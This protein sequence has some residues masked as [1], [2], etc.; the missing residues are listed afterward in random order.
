MPLHPPHRL[1]LAM[2]YLAILGVGLSILL[3]VTHWQLFHAASGG[4]YC[5]VNETFDCRTVALSRYAVV[6]GLPLP[7]WGCAGFLTIGLAAWL[8]SRLAFPLALLGAVLSIALLLEEVLHVGAVCLLCEGVHA[9][10]VILAVLAFFARRQPGT[11]PLQW[12]REAWVLA[13]G[14]LGLLVAA[15]VLPPYWAASQWLQ[16][17]QVPHGED[18]AGHPWIGAVEPRLVIEEWVDYRCPHCAVSSRRMARLV[19]QH[20]EV[21]RLV[22]R[23][24]P[25]LRCHP[26]PRAENLCLHVRAAICAGK[27]GKFWEMDAWLFAQPGVRTRAD[28]EP[29]LASQAIAVDTFDA[30]LQDPA[31]FARA[32]AEYDAAVEANMLTTPRYRIAEEILGPAEFWPTVESRIAHASK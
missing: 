17:P 29:A 32:A 9:V 27:Q 7:L 16:G 28:L 23:H 13:P 21:I 11:A 12:R 26:V 31:T 15:L 22:R 25:G 24:Q 30:C 1:R 10:F 4:S 19:M 18:E 6:A 20:P 8:R 3:E 2:V 14:I 5:S